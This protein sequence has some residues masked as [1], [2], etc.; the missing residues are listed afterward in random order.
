M[1]FSFAEEE[2]TETIKTNHY[3]K[4]LIVDDEKEVHNITK[5]VLKKFIFENKGIEWFSAFNGDEAIEILKNNSDID[6]ILLDV[7]ME[8]DNA[9][10]IVAKRIRNELNNQ[11]I[12][13]VL[14]TGQPGSAP[15]KQVIVDYDI[16]DYKEKTELTSTKLFT[17]MVSSLRTS[18]YI[19]TIDKNRIGLGKIIESSKSIFQL[20]SLIEFTEGVLIQLVSIL[21]LNDSISD[22]KASHGFFATLNNN[23][24]EVLAKVGKYKDSDN[25]AIITPKS[26]EY[27]DQ[28]YKKRKGYFQD[29]IYVGFFES[30]NQQ[31]IFLYIEGCKDLNEEDRKFLEIFSNNISI[32]FDNICLNNEIIDTQKEIIE[33]LGEVVENRSQEAAQH[34]NRVAKISYILAIAY[35][36][37]EKEAEKLKMASPMH[38]IGKIGIPDRILL[39]P[40]RLDQQEYT[41]I[42]THTQIGKEILEGSK[43]EILKLAKSIAYEHHEKWDGTGYPQ[44]LRGNEISIHGRITAI[45]DVFD[46]LTQERVYK[47]PWSMEEALKLFN[48]EKGKQFDPK[49][50]DLFV[51]NLDK[52]K[53][54]IK[55]M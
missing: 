2:S 24:F 14:R 27:L 22:L 13:I 53:E 17:T 29:D 1:S 35:G 31:C 11:A 50:V 30:S 28:A 20:N 9:G 46:A 16:D 44:G 4:V 3:W 33:R 42:K 45:A 18:R 38:D 19:K 39:K 10:L 55:D 41:I 43:R 34:V 25:K 49:L 36:L 23:Q 54:S 37:D 12:R 7:V 26:I 32:A 6:M 40:A 48:T 15:E 21:N 52:I 8:T 47:E 5:S 51:E